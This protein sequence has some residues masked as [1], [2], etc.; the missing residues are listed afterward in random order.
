[1]TL[2]EF[3]T[4]H[5][6]VNH[7]TI[8]SPHGQPQQWLFDMRPLLLDSAALNE[9][10][11]QF[12]QMF[13]DYLPFQVA[14]I[15]TAAI[16]LVTA[17]ILKAPLP[18]NGLIIRK[19]RKKYGLQN[20]IEGKLISDL[21]VVIVDDVCNSAGSLE[22]V[23][24]VLADAG[25]NVVRAFV[26]MSYDTTGA[27]QWSAQHNIPISHLFRSAEFGYRASHN[28]RPSSKE[29]VWTFAPRQPYLYLA[30]AKST[31]LLYDDRS[32]YYGS[33]CG[34][35]WCL[36]ARSGRIIWQYDTQTTN[37]KGIVS[38]A[39]LYQ[40][41]VIFGAYNGTLYALDRDTGA[42]IWQNQCCDWIGSSPCIVGDNVW[43]GL[44]R[45]T[46]PHG[47]LTKFR[48]ADGLAL[49]SIPFTNMLH[50]SARYHDGRLA[51]GTNDGKFVM[52]DEASCKILWEK[53]CGDSKYPPAWDVEGN[54]IVFGGF[55][56]GI[57]VC[58]ATSGETKLRI[59]TDD[60]VYSTPLV[61]D[62]IGYMGSADEY[63][64]VFDL[65]AHKLLHKLHL[66]EKI[67]SSPT[68]INGEILIGT[69][70]GTLYGF[71][72]KT[73]NLTTEV[74]FP[75]RITNSVTYSKKHGLY[76]VLDYTNKIWAMR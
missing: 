76:Y 11:D 3:I 31:P 55:D 53:Y 49:G 38:S 36:D 17:I 67:H 62:G 48:L 65:R 50:G 70:G 24:V 51:F 33:D 23:R 32:L 47:M 5:V 10:A 15:E 30:V 39:A 43:I 35:F 16:P 22:K 29:T 73:M 74:W 19:K 61:A 59:Q 27:R 66:G 34:T 26:V 37:P 2:G 54:Q 71:E 64:Y 52:A 4:E 7:G 9:A 68:C 12:W 13:R 58:D 1:M 72:S 28:V 8:V 60:I 41:M 46:A 69:S 25:A 14:G 18:T 63:F 20:L 42:V 44:E 57:Y 6:L 56:G 21:P 75:E 40:N 45:K